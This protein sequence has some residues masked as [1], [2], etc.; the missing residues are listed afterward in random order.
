MISAGGDCAHRSRNSKLI[1]ISD[2][3]LPFDF[4]WWRARKSQPRSMAAGSR[5]TDGVML[6]AQAERRLGAECLAAV[7][8]NGRDASRDW[9]ITSVVEALPA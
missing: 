2:T 5:R 7:I 1:T 6:L 8:P 3:L 9:E 4:P